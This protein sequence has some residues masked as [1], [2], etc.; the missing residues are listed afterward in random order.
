MSNWAN[1]TKEQL[2]EVA[3]DELQPVGGE[4][5]DPIS[6][7]YRFTAPKKPGATPAKVLTE[8]D[9]FEGSYEGSFSS[10]T[11]EQTTHKVRTEDSGLIGLPGSGQ[12]NKLMAKVVKG[13]RV[14]I[15]Y[16]GQE[17]IKNGKWA[18]KKAHTFTVRASQLIS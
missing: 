18:G 8:G 7:F 16:R 12:L 14:K 3:D 2:K 13:A 15:V 17:A 4:G 1:R 5:F 11:F 6:T 10:G 9:T